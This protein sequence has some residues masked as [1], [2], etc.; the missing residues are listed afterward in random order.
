MRN[1]TIVGFIF[2]ILIFSV[3][4]YAQEA[5]ESI[6]ELPSL[7]L[8]QKLDRAVGNMYA[9]VIAG[10]AYS[11]S[12][13]KTPEDY[14]QFVGSFFAPS[15]E[16]AKGKGVSAF[17]IGMYINGQSD[18]YFTMEILEESETRV[19]GR[20]TG[21]DRIKGMSDVFGVSGDEFLIVWEKAWEVIADYLGLELKQTRDEDWIVFTVEEKH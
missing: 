4:S 12:L 6:I 3:F 15:W 20:W 14:G 19:K 10:I 9:F 1:I 18:K 7:N 5:E 8:E 13:G 2:S 17:V 21:L 16:G 11:K